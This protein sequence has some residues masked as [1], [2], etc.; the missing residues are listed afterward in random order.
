MTSV[1]LGSNPSIVFAWV[2][3]PFNEDTEAIN[4]LFLSY[5]TACG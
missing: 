3:Q 5:A 4:I 1:M 2:K